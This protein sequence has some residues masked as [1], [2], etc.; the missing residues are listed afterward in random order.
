MLEC[1]PNIAGLLL[2]L[3][4]IA[5]TITADAIQDG[6]LLQRVLLD[7]TKDAARYPG[8]RKHGR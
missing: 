6:T 8:T 1:M 7:A 3:D 5:A 4:M 2:M